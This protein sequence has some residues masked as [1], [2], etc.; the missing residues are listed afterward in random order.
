LKIPLSAINWTPC[1]RII[2]SRYPA[3]N[4]FEKIAADPADWELLLEV[5][6]LT[7]PSVNAGNLSAVEPE[8]R[9]SGAGFGL[10]LSSFTFHD[11]AGTRFMNGDFGAYYAALDLKTAVAETVHHRVLFMRATNEPAQDLDQLLILADVAGS[12][13]DIRDMQS[14]LPEVYDPLSYKESQRFAAHLRDSGSLGVVYKSV[15]Q[16]PGECVAVWRARVLANPREDRHITYRWDGNRI[17][18]YYDKRS[19]QALS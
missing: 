17:T 11:P 15:R 3:I 13:H 5:E 18:G 7:D 14:A 10:V 8:D 12:L 19:Y 6:R 1:Y 9:T 16:T 2:G 4:F